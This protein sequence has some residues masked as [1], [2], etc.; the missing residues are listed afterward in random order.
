[1][2]SVHTLTKTTSD[3]ATTAAMLLALRIARTDF[4][5]PKD[6]LIF[7]QGRGGVAPRGAVPLAGASVSLTRNSESHFELSLAAFIE[8]DGCGHPVCIRP[9]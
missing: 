7:T 6:F 2:P 4:K 8:D 9:G 3:D 1:M 5:E